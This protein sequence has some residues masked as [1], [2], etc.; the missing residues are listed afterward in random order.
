FRYAFGI[1]FLTLLARSRSVDLFGGDRRGLFWRGISGGVASV[2]YFL[3][4]QFTTLTHATLLNYTSIIFG[5][6]FAV[7]ALGERMGRRG[8]ATVLCALCGVVL[9]IRP[10][11]GPVRFGD[12]IALLSGI[13]AGSAIVQIRRLRQGETAYAIFFYFNLLGIPVALLA[14]RLSGA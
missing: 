7:F 2:C 13:V 8:V 10:E 12:G 14:L 1:A 6:F 11:A 5:P 4:I 3:G 9:V